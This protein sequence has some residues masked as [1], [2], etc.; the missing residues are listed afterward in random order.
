MDNRTLITIALTANQFEKELLEN[1]GEL[2]PELEQSLS[3]ANICKQKKVDAYHAIL[4][5]CKSAQLELKEKRDLIDTLMKKYKRHEEYLKLNLKEAMSI[6]G[7]HELQ[8]EL[9]RFKLHTRGNKL[10]ID[11][12]EVIPHTFFDKVEQFILNKERLEKALEAGEYI[13]GAHLDTINVLTTSAP[14]KTIKLGE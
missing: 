12:E 7:T 13:E 5:R 10:V 9:V 14:S 11:N 8:G 4:E 2:T 3:V 6:S 1:N